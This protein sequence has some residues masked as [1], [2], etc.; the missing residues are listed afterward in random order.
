LARFAEKSA[1]GSPCRVLLLSNHGALCLG[2]TIEEALKVAIDLEEIA[3]KEILSRFRPGSTREELLEHYAPALNTEEVDPAREMK[4]LDE[5]RAHRPGKTFIVRKGE[6]LCAAARAGQTVFPMVDDLAQLVGPTLP[7][8]HMTSSF[9]SAGVRRILKHRNAVLVPGL[10]C[11]CGG[12][13]Q[14]EVEATA[15]VVEKG[16]RVAIES[17]YLGGGHRISWPERLLMRFIF[18]AKYSKKAAG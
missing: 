8:I 1:A 3:E 18:L 16:C 6:Y 13:D 11:V 2:S 15:M 4:L 9:T 17:S 5:L 10:G 7:V 14:S 12:N